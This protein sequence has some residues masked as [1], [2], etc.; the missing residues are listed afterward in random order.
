MAARKK[1]TVSRKGK[2]PRKGKVTR[3][4]KAPRLTAQEMAHTQREISV[5]EFF[6][7][8]RDA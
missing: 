8:N 2:A 4:G 3:K 7:K 5:A 6:A 1:K